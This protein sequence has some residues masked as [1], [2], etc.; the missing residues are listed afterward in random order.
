MWKGNPIESR[1]YSSNLPLYDLDVY[2]VET[3]T[4]AQKKI[5]VSEYAD[6]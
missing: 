6:R 2:G 1:P 3:S 4:K 5:L